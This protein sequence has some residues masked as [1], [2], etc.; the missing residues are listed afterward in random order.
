MN[1][2]KH[3]LLA[4]GLLGLSAWAQPAV[5]PLPNT[6]AHNDYEHTH[7]LFDAL[8]QGF[9][10]VEADI[11]L[12]DGKL[13]VAHERREVRPERTLEALYLDPLLAQVRAHGGRLYPGGP[14]CYLLID[15]KTAAEPTYRALRDVLA[16]Y[17]E[18]L[19]RF[20]PTSTETNAIT[21]VISGNRARQIMASEA[22]RYAAV[23]GRLPDLA[24]S[25][26]AHLIPWIS[27]NW[28][29]HF[30]WRGW[31]QMPADQQAELRRIVDQ[32]HAQGRKVRFWGGPDIP[33]LWSVEL[34]AGVDFINTDK[35]AELRQFLLA[36]HPPGT[37]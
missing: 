27:D 7:P 32:A 11:Y 8:A 12:I 31:Q 36:A 15:V 17:Q 30:T 19:T 21:V 3:L 6:H 1:H 4:L 5:S 16:R 29:L 20:T 33:A 22:V 24:G 25:T 13:L 34:A 37:R 18:M 23:D 9:C 26:N 35:L 28:S 10:S 14:D 2:V